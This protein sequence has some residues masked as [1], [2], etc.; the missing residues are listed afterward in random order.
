MNAR[1]TQ[2]VSD[3]EAQIPTVIPQPPIML[4]LNVV[5]FD[6]RVETFEYHEWRGKG[7]TPDEAIDDWWSQRPTDK[8]EMLFWRVKPELDSDWDFATKTRS[9]QVSSRAA[10]KVAQTTETAA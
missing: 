1:L 10:W 8:L 9:W 4:G 2:L 7:E 3:F 6:D 5:P